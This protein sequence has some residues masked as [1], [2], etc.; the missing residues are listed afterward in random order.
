MRKHVR[1][2]SGGYPVPTL[3]GA[4][5]LRFGLSPDVLVN[6]PCWSVCST[7]G[8]P[9]FHA[10]RR[11]AWIVELGGVSVCGVVGVAGYARVGRASLVAGAGR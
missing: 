9:W 3:V 5:S 7:M 11:L 1:I 10:Y 2:L 4:R 8:M 6:F